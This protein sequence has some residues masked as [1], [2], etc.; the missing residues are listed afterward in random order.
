MSGSDSQVGVAKEI[1]AML[2][3]FVK[4]LGLRFG[5]SSHNLT[6]YYRIL[7]TED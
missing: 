3:G 4:L 5:P 1:A 2:I 6:A 7:A